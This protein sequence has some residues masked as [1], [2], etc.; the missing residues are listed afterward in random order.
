[1]I[2]CLIVGDSIAVG[3]HKFK[4][5]C[6]SYSKG[7]INSYQWINQNISKLPLNAKTVIIS[8]GSNDHKWV[9]TEKEL[10]TLRQMT[11]AD[12]VYWILP[13][14]NL[15]A[16]EVSIQ[17]I[18][19]LVKEIAKEYGDVVIPITKLQADGIHPSW[20]GYKDIAEKTK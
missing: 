17:Y 7:G 3:T 13:A 10:R 2:D 11:Q 8:L 14:G 15:K 12:R 6:V 5:E 9:K 16:S 1:M 20:A 19:L 4:P 18:Q